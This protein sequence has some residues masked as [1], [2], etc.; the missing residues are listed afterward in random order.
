MFP[1]E[2]DQKTGGKHLNDVDGPSLKRGPILR[3]AVHPKWAGVPAQDPSGVPKIVPGVQEASFDLIPK[4]DYDLGLIYYV[5][6]D[7]PSYKSIGNG[8]MR[9]F[10]TKTHSVLVLLTFF[11]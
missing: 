11:S 7:S 9:F 1:F 4:R 2:K 3:A 5:S 6:C 10:F 8:P